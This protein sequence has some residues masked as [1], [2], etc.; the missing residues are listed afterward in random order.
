MKRGDEVPLLLLCAVLMLI[1]PMDTILRAREACALFAHAVLPGLFPFL[2]VMLLI[3]SRL[4]RGAGFFPMAMMGLVAGSP[5]GAR[6]S[7]FGSFTPK[8]YR[9]F[10]LLT[11]VMSPMFLLGTVPL[12]LKG[13]GMPVLLATWLGAFV[14]AGLSLAFPARSCVL[15][16]NENGRLSLS[17]AVNRAAQ[18]M[19]SVCGCMVMGSCLG[20]MAEK[21][22]PMQNALL[23]A[24]VQGILEVTKGVR[25]LS[26]ISFVDGR[27]LAAWTAALVSF[28][29]VSL[30]MQNFSFY[31]KGAMPMVPYLLLKGLHAGL[32]FLFAY[33]LVPLFPVR[34]LETAAIGFS[35]TRIVP[36][37]WGMAFLLS[38]IVLKWRRTKQKEA[39]ECC[40]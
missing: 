19:L 14:T 20:L 32:A 2:T 8:G 30:Q 39:M 21:Y 31:K 4:K 3:T 9:A 25:D 16:E 1:H 5:A 37:L 10:V 12:W 36:P 34:A 7:A 28:G 18:T 29:G 23:K 15:L 27:V 40:A 26:D 24:A 33:L 22:I 35:N 38:E 13:Y 6:L 11:G 17:E